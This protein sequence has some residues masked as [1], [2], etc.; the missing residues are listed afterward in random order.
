MKNAAW[1]ASTAARD[2]ARALLSPAGLRGAGVEVVW[3]AAHAALYPMGALRERTRKG[4]GRYSLT[5]LNPVKRSLILGDV[6]AAGTPIVLIHG[7]V[8]NRSI[9]TL[10]RRALHRRGFGRVVTMNYN[11]LTHD[12][13]RAAHRL[14]TLVD[15]LCQET[16]YERV[17]VVGHSMG[18]LVA[19]YYV[20]RLDG[21]QRIHTLAT[22]GTPHQ[23]TR[24]AHLFVGRALKSLRVGSAVVRELEEPAPQCRTRFIA[25]WS[26]LDELVVPKSSAR[27]DHPD[28]HARNVFVRGAGHL[29]LP[30]DGRV[31][32]E[33]VTAF[34]HLDVDGSTLASGVTSIAP[35]AAANLRPA[36]VRRRRAA[37][38][39]EDAG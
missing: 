38:A 28:L 18:G 7:W 36:P 22:L 27:I 32:H 13:P 37:A 19:R 23:G 12:V 2:T 35:D 31:V 39:S 10:L 1:R 34:A 16:G 30:I 14:G 6:E 11:V 3:A 5:G 26:D 4:Q 9:F 15:Q 33:I 20:Q 17:H 21:D 24:A 25:F 29:S 8:D